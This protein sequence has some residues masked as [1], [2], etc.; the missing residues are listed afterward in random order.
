VDIEVLSDT[1]KKAN[2]RIR[3]K[4]ALKAKGRQGESIGET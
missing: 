2:E 3:E 4:K 1:L